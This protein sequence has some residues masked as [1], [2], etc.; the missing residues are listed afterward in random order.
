TARTRTAC[1]PFV[2]V[3][4]AVVVAD[5]VLPALERLRQIHPRERRGRAPPP[6]PPPPPPP[7]R[8]RAPRAAPRS[9]IPRRT[10]P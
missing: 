7:A 8:R 9:A 2:S 10:L 5:R 3:Q 4:V 1:G 6:P